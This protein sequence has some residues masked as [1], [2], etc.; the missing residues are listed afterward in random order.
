VA[1]LAT[2][3]KLFDIFAPGEKVRLRIN[4][5]TGNQTMSW[6]F[7]TV[8]AITCMNSQSFNAAFGSQKPKKILTAQSWVAASGDAMNSVRI[9][10]VDL[11]IKERKFTH[12]VNVITELNNNITGIDFMHRNKFIYNVNMR[13]VKF[14]DTHLNTICANKQITMPAMTSS[15]VTA[16]FNEES[17]KE[18]TYITTIHCTSTLTISGIPALVSMDENNNC[19]VMGENCAPYDITIERNNLMG[20]VKIEEDELIQF[21]DA[22]ASDICAAIQDKLPKVQKAKLSRDEIAR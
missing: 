5:Q 8:A 11:W 20:L 19:K 3:N 17:H 9:Y 1:S 18:K 22:T 7:N 6:L 13:Q 10:E 16:K 4:V 15:I 2:C 14:A 12:P 21:T